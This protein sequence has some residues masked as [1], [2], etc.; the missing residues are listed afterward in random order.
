MPL[1]ITDYPTQ[2]TAS[3]GSP[4]YITGTISTV[5]GTGTQPVTGTVNIGN[6]PTTQQISV[7]SSVP[8]TITS[9]TTTVT[10]ATAANLN[11]T[12]TG[13]VTA[14]IAGSVTGIT[15]GVGITSGTL[16]SVGSITGGVG[17]NS[18]TLTNVTT[19][20]T[21][22]NPVTV[23]QLTATN[24]LATVTQGGASG[25]GVSGAWYVRLSDGT[26]AVPVKAASTAAVAADPALVVAVSPNN[27][28]TTKEI[29]STATSLAGVFVSSSTTQV[30]ASSGS[31]IGAT[32]FNPSTTIPVFIAMGQSATTSLY[33]VKL[34]PGGYFEV[35]QNFT[36]V[37]NGVVA[38]GTQIIYVTDMS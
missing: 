26:T 25:G 18:G 3:A 35:P 9:G 23:T 4:V 12:V 27:T 6:F 20:G 38:T 21:I 16:T 1:Y 17:I 15:N 37:V 10:Q 11:A 24:L 36:G 32:L 13:T 19:V 22:T 5:P 2:V 29:R 7:T 28:V 31:R 30:L 14:N 34:G 8:T 33:S